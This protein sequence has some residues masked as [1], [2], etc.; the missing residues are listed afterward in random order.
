MTHNRLCYR[1][2]PALQVTTGRAHT[3]LH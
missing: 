1:I 3:K 2:I